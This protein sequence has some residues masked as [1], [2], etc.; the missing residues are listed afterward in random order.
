MNIRIFSVCVCVVCVCVCVLCVCVCSCF[1]YA[2]LYHFLGFQQD[3]CYKTFEIDQL[4]PSRNN[5]LPFGL[6]PSVRDVYAA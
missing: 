6:I 5:T 3:C 4:S 1:V 2:Q